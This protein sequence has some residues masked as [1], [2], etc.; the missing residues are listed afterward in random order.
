MNETTVIVTGATDVARRRL[1]DAPRRRS[2]SC[3]RGGPRRTT[4]WTR[5]LRRACWRTAYA[6]GR[7]PLR[8]SCRDR[9][10][11]VP[12]PDAARRLAA[13]ADADG[14]AAERRADGRADGR[15]RRR[16]PAPRCRGRLRH[17]GANADAA[18]DAETDL[19]G[20]GVGIAFACGSILDL[21]GAGTRRAT[22]PTS[23]R[24]ADVASAAIVPGDNATALG[25]VP[26]RACG[27][28]APAPRPARATLPRPHRR[29]ATENP[30]ARRS[31]SRR[32]RRA[33]LRGRFV[34]ALQAAA[35]A[36][37]TSAVAWS[38][39][40]RAAWAAVPSTA[41][42]WYELVLNASHL[43]VSSL[44]VRPSW[45]TSSAARAARPGPAGE[46]KRRARSSR[47]PRA[48]PQARPRPPC[49]SRSRA[50]SPTL[51]L[52]GGAA[53]VLVA[54]ASRWTRAASRHRAICRLMSGQRSRTPG[55]PWMRSRRQAPL[56]SSRGTRASSRRAPAR[57][58]RA[59]TTWSRPSSTTR[60]ASTN[61]SVRPRVGGGAGA[62]GGGGDRTVPPPTARWPW[63]GGYDPDDK[64]CAAGGD[65]GAFGDGRRRRGRRPNGRDRRADRGAG[66]YVVTPVAAAT[67]G[68]EATAVATFERGRRTFRA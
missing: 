9:R 17:P 6:R 35:P 60:M 53:A 13:D 1:D 27:V 57:S 52:V 46:A 16:R 21:P 45:R 43:N 68:R 48:T 24:S 41:T 59:R 42:K 7:R 14:Q 15:L 38:I 20:G 44:D 56:A 64:A 50:V 2:S 8:P 28:G 33:A 51:T 37:A 67:D 47:Q 40:T 3:C 23:G 18:W 4:I 26:R 31:S 22:G 11:R 65:G 30:P 61:G 49:A 34:S 25:G 66:A 54:A 12:R 39:G 55:T 29:P 19:G 62:A 63:R 5:R 10:R 32:P 36:G 58:R